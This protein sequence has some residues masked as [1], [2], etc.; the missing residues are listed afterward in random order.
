M[1]A[2]ARLRALDAQTSAISREKLR[3]E[4]LIAALIDE[5]RRRLNFVV[6]KLEARRELTLAGGTF[7]LRIDRIDS[8]EGG[9]YAILDYKSG[10]VR[11]LRWDGESLRDP[12]LIAYLLAVP[13]LDVQAVANVSLTQ[14][15]AKFTGKASRKGLLPGVSGLPGM[16]PSKVPAEEID[17]AWLREISRWSGTAESLAAAYI[18]GHA[19]VQPTPDNCR[20][21]H[22]TILCRRVELA[23]ADVEPDEAP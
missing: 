6:E 16:L 10:E 9:G 18:A 7:D 8:I 5:E 23:A 3:L 21:C 4:R 15:R 11:P 14:G 22:L 13:D 19:P 1:D 20:N 17:A 12:Q 2:L